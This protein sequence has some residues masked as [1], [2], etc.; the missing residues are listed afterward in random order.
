MLLLDMSK[1]FDTVSRK[2]LFEELEEVLEEDELHLI[3]IL[4]NRSQIQVKVGNSTGNMFET[5]KG[6]MQGDILSAIL[7]IFYMAKC[8]KKPIKTKTKGFLSKPKYAD[9]ITYAGTSKPQAEAG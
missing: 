5:F 1:A 8:L 3:S 9:D 2:T 7:F 4:T 6:I